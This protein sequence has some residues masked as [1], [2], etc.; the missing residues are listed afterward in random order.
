MTCNLCVKIW[1]EQMQCLQ[2]CFLEEASGI[3]ENCQGILQG[4]QVI[5]H[6]LAAM[7]KGSGNT[8]REQLL[9]S[10]CAR[11]W[12]YRRHA[13]VDFS[14]GFDCR[15][16]WESP[17]DFWKEVLNSRFAFWVNH[18]GSSWRQTLRMWADTQVACWVW[19]AFCPTYGCQTGSFFF[20]FLV[21]WKSPWINNTRAK[22]WPVQPAW[23]V[24][25]YHSSG[26]ITF[27]L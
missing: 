11:L 18:L 21:D 6:P 13:G 1:R 14:A 20:F 12:G 24:L 26:V 3:P 9:V 7:L 22:F 10:K 16:T 17:V 19:A 2:C 15:E 5:T 8:G 25:V 27:R 23:Q 4:F